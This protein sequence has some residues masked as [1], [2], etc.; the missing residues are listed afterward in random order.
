MAMGLWEVLALEARKDSGMWVIR[1]VEGKYWRWKGLSVDWGG[2]MGVR[3]YSGGIIQTKG[4]KNR[5]S[6]L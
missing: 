4:Y 3:G 6:I 2:M 5:N 1:E